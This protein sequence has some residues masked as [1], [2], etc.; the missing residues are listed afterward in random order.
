MTQTTTRRYFEDVQ[1]NVE[2]GEAEEDAAFDHEEARMSPWKQRGETGDKDENMG[3]VAMMNHE[4]RDRNQRQKGKWT[5]Q[6]MTV[7]LYYND[8]KDSHEERDHESKRERVVT[9][10][11]VRNGEKGHGE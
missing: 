6:V 9:A 2:D 1:V 8:T 7:F 4:G 5:V 10:T 11:L 3:L